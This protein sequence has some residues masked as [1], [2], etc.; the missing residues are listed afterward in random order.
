V[1]AGLSIGALAAIEGIYAAEVFDG[2]TLGTSLGIMSLVRGIG[3][4]LGPTVGGALIDVFDKQA[5]ALALAFVAAVVATIL[6]PRRPR[7]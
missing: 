6:V 5:A 7:A 3:A 4:A 1:V 2:P